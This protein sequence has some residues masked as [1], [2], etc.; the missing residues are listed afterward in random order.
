MPVPK[1][2]RSPKADAGLAWDWSDNA[3]RYTDELI[4][5]GGWDAMVTAHAW[6][7]P[8][9]DP[10]TRKSDFKLPHHRVL[11]GRVRVV[12]EGVRS[13]MN[14]LAASRFQ[15]QDYQLH[16]PA[17]EVREVYEHLAVHLE[18]FDEQ[19]PAIL[20][21]WSQGDGWPPDPPDA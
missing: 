5:H 18:E 19:P 8:S 12:L 1:P 11:D 17:N 14:I 15:P 4:D 3:P 10:P 9:G 16:I 2:H 20:D 13:A 6:Y 21:G 7:A